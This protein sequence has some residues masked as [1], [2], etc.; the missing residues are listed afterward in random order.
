MEFSAF[1][2]AEFLAALRPGMKLYY[3]DSS[4]A[5]RYEEITKKFDSVFKAR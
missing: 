2:Y 5:D 1:R 3:A 4:L